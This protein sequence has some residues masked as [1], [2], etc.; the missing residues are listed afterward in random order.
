VLKLQD[1]ASQCGVTDRQIQRL[2]KKYESEVV[3]HFER[4]GVN[5]TWLDEE[6]CSILRSKMK[7]KEIAVADET[8][9]L[10]IKELEDKIERKDVIIERL[11]QREQEKDLLIEDMKS[12]RL[13]LEEKNQEKI[14]SAVKEAED[15]MALKHIEAE[16]KLQNHYQEEIRQLQERLEEAEKPWYK[17][18]FKKKD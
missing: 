12:E 11:Q 1:F 14:E 10:R 6:A 3:G 17:K 8:L 2:L 16:R 5:G 7:V 18:I 4:K 13:L 15:R 9:Q